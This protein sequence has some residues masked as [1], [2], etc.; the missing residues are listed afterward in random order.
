MHFAREDQNKLPNKFLNENKCNLFGCNQQISEVEQVVV[1]LWI[2]GEYLRL[3][4]VIYS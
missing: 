2:E 1:M 4:N 3:E